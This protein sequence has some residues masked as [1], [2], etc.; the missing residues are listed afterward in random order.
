M[1]CCEI[2]NL[3]PDYAL[4]LLDESNRALVERHLATGCEQCQSVLDE[5]YEAAAMIPMTDTKVRTPVAPPPELK[6]ELMRRVRGVAAEREP[7]VPA[8]PLSQ[9]RRAPAST[10]AASKRW[11]LLAYATVAAVAFVVGTQ[12]FPAPQAPQS[13]QLTSAQRDELYRQRMTQIEQSFDMGAVR[14]ATAAPAGDAEH[15]LGAAVWDAQASEVHLIL[16]DLSPAADDRVLQAWVEDRDGVYTPIGTVEPDDSREATHRFAVP[17][18]GGAPKALVV[19]EESAATTAALPA[20]QAPTG[21]LRLVAPF[22]R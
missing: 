9:P 13:D 14:L 22:G 21:D 4:Q 7:E 8:A 12:F 20:G 10:D 3:L 2:E 19:T 1:R 16:F 5:L 11:H 17:R 18:T 15:K 6:A